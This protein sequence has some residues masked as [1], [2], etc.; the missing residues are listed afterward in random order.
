MKENIWY[1]IFGIIFSTP[2]AKK[3]GEYASAKEA[4]GKAGGEAGRVNP[5]IA[6]LYSLCL[7]AGMLISLSYLVK[8][9]YNPFIYFNF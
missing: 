8:G 1:F 7:I 4:G 5:L 2:I 6:G 3:L 9:A